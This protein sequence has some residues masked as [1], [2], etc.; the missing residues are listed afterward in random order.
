[1]LYVTTRSNSDIFTSNRALVENR[2]PDGGLYVPL[3]MP[4]F[5]PDEIEGLKHKTLGQRMAD[6]LNLF[7]GTRLSGWD[8]DL[9]IG[10][11]P[12]RL[13]SIGR[14]EFL[15]ESWHNPAGD[16]DWMVRCLSD[17]LGGSQEEF[18]SDW[19]SLVSRIAVLFGAFGEL[20]EKGIAGKVDV[21]VPSGDFSGC[22]AAWYARQMGL[23]VG[24][25]ICCC[26]EN[27]APWDLIHRG[28]LRTNS[29]SV[30]TST[31]LCDLAVPRD[32]ERLVFACGGYG[33]TEKFVQAVRRGG[34]YCPDDATA[35]R[36][37]EGLFVS[38]IGEFRMKNTVKAIN[39]IKSVIIGPYTARAYSGLLDYRART[40]ENRY[41]IILSERSPQCDVDTVADAL[42]VSTEELNELLK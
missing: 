39:S 35:K 15:A 21:S 20:L 40:G 24:N 29:V 10:K 1:M 5:S 18:S 9:T 14:R 34:M 12:V 26:N 32:L 38:V 4:C 2:G 6:V 33:E 16:F 17:A 25:V 28:E 3:H 22:M 23:P 30:R 31:P 42:G 19:L 37:H 13:V 27:S 36:L 8:L 41:A 7:F 11:A